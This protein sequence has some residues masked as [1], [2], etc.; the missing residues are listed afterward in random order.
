M[1]YII[2][3][4]EKHARERI[5]FLKKRLLGATTLYWFFID[6]DDIVVFISIFSLALSRS[7]VALAVAMSVTRIMNTTGPQKATLFVL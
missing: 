4:L 3:K 5:H 1:H 6:D 2:E 7:V